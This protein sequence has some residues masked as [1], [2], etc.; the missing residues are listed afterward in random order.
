LARLNRAGGALHG[1]RF[2]G[3]L[4]VELAHEGVEAG[5]LLRAVYAWWPGRLLFQGEMH[6]LMAAVLL[7]MAGLDALDGDAEP[8]PPDGELREVEQA[9]WAGEENTVGPDGSR[10]TSF[11][12]ELLEG[13]DGEI[14]VDSRASQ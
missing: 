9:V 10:Q 14:F 5:L 1:E 8:E 11:Q 13:G 7:G 6:A 12:E 2:V 3:P 4:G